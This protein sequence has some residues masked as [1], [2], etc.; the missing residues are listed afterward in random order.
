[1]N[2]TTIVIATSINP[3]VAC[4]PVAVDLS[5]R[6]LNQRAQQTIEPA[7]MAKSKPAV[8]KLA[9]IWTGVNETG[10]IAISLRQASR[11]QGQK[12]L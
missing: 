4:G 12:Q 3:M 10:V 5:R 7:N 2:R 6:P 8:A 1:M 9:R 11:I